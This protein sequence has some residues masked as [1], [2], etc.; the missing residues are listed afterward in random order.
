MRTAKLFLQIR[1]AG[2]VLDLTK[3]TKFKHSHDACGALATGAQGFRIGSQCEILALSRC[4]PLVSKVRRCRLQD[5]NDAG[6]S[7]DFARLLWYWRLMNRS[8][9][10]VNRKHMTRFGW[11]V[12]GV[13]R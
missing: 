5:A 7:L 4:F 6:T 10:I 12:E 3:R 11:A 13:V 9:R 2:L 8:V 1:F